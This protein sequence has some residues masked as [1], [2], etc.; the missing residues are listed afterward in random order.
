[1]GFMLI[2]NY[3]YPLTFLSSL[4]LSF[5]Y[6]NSNYVSLF[7]RKKLPN[8]HVS[9]KGTLEHNLGEWTRLYSI[10]WTW[11]ICVKMHLK[12]YWK[13]L[14]LSLR[15]LLLPVMDKPSVS[16]L[17]LFCLLFCCLG[18][19]HIMISEHLIYYCFRTEHAWINWEWSGSK[20]S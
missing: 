19:N 4:F 10:S 7:N 17:A 3:I 9:V 13:C 6:C 16:V 14:L 12:E 11:L 15:L 1:M 5:I 2:Y 8:W 18:C 20:Q